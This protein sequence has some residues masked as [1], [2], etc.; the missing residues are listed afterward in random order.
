M[1]ILRGFPLAL[2]AEASSEGDIEDAE[3]DDVD[4]SPD[5]DVGDADD[6][7]ATLFFL[8]SSSPSST[9]SSSSPLSS[10][11][12]P[13]SRSRSPQEALRDVELHDA[14]DELARAPPGEALRRRRIGPRRSDD[15]AA[16][17]RRATI[18]KGAA[19]KAPAFVV[20][21]DAASAAI[22][23]VGPLLLP[24]AARG[25]GD[26]VM[27]GQHTREREKE[28][29]ILFFSFLKRK[30]KKVKKKSSRCLRF[31]FTISR[32]KKTKRKRER[33]ER[34]REIFLLLSRV[35]KPGFFRLGTAEQL[36]CAFS[37]PSRLSL[38]PKRRG[39]E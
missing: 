25:R 34:E 7:E 20:D 16:A 24:T 18:D 13:L 6:V 21:G 36:A 31:L 4:A 15:A 12:P 27:V 37:A 29:R 2:A 28:R 30:E 17:P 5:V 22:D 38:V 32:R 8:P 1:L 35:S 26:G 9:F 23:T 19:A 39:R 3:D 11:L 14:A 10:S 33:A